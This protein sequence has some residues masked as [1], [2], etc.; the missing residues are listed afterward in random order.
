MTTELLP[1][2]FCGSEAHY[3][4]NVHPVDVWWVEC[5]NPNCWAAIKVVSDK[6]KATEIWNTRQPTK[7]YIPIGEYDH[8]GNY[9][10]A[11]KTTMEEAQAAA[12]RCP[13]HYDGID[14]QVWDVGQEDEMKS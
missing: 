13:M 5:M 1:C 7:L 6:T 2:P 8:S 14:I 12:E 3:G 10:I 4:R 9:I 11:I